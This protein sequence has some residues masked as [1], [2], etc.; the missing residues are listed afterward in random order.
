M[1]TNISPNTLF[2]LS[3]SS[4]L[5][6][7]SCKFDW[8]KSSLASFKRYAVQTPT[9]AASW[10]KRRCAE[11]IAG[12]YCATQALTGLAED[13]RVPATLQ[14][15]ITDDGSPQ[16]PRGTLGSI[17]HS[18]Q[19]AIAIA[20]RARDFAGLGIDCETLLT[21]AAAA[22]LAPWVL[23]PNDFNCSIEPSLSYGFWVTLVFSAKESLFKALTPTYKNIVDVGHFSSIFSVSKITANS[24]VLH[25]EVSLNRYSQLGTRFQLFY[26][27]DH[28]HIIT[29][30]LLA[31]K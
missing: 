9:E 11:Y 2:D 26:T 1:L 30:A 20:A 14:L 7:C 16:W 13:S 4:N 28:P 21:D 8:Q 31:Y 19:R 17:S 22:E 15:P 23:Q 29:M 10:S 18:Q 6:F 24:L 25:S 27:F 12:R 3:L 5:R